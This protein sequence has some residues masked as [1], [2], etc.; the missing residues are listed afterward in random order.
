MKI[1]GERR[2]IGQCG[3]VILEFAVALPVMMV[4]LIGIID[5]G[6]LILS[7]QQVRNAARSATEYAISNGY[8][9]TLLTATNAVKDPNNSNRN[10][11]TEGQRDIMFATAAAVSNTSNLTSAIV[12]VRILWQTFTTGFG[13]PETTTITN[14]A[15]APMSATSAIPLTGAY[16]ACFSTASSQ[17]I[18]DTTGNAFPL[19]G[20]PCNGPNENGNFK[21]AGYLTVVTSLTYLPFVTYAGLPLPP[22]KLR[23]VS[24]ARVH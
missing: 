19:C 9:V 22:V 8:E 12:P 4:L 3:A 17:L 14:A 5:F 23:S 10:L 7:Q 21:S 11:V 6:L 16:C 24:T 15:G 20:N 13:G 18:P 2:A 1:F